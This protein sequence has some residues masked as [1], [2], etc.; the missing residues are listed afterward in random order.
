MILGFVSYNFFDWYEILGTSP[1]VIKGLNGI[2]L[3]SFTL[4]C[5]TLIFKFIGN[6]FLALQ[7][8]ALSSTL[9]TGGHFLSLL[10]IY[11]LTKLTNGDLLIVAIVY[12][13]SPL[14]VYLVAYPIMFLVNIHIYVLK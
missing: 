7:M 5:L 12:T 14:I 8:P 4:F 2:M 11:F 13:L 9:T 1:D 6:I 3:I 10:I